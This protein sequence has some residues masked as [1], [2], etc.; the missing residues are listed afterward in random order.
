MSLTA[1]ESASLAAGQSLGRLKDIL[2]VAVSPEGRRLITGGKE[3][4]VIVWDSAN[5]QPLFPLPLTGHTDWVPSVAFS[6]DGRKMVSGCFDRTARVWDAV[7]GLEVSV[8]KGHTGRITS[9]AFAPD[10]RQIATASYDGTVKI[11]DAASGRE[12]DTLRGHTD[13]VWCVA[14]SPKGDRIASGGLDGTPRIRNARSGEGVNEV[15]LKGHAGMTASVDFSPDGR[16]V[17]TSGEDRTARVWDAATGRQELV[18][19]GHTSPVSS[20]RFFPD[21][22]RILT[23]GG[24]NRIKVWD[25]ATGRELLSLDPR[26]NSSGALA[27][28]PDGRKIVGSA[29]GNTLEVWEAATPGQVAAWEDD[30]RAISD[31]ITARTRERTAKEERERAIQASGAGAIRQWLVLAPVSIAA[32]SVNQP[33]L[34]QIPGENLLRPAAGDRVQV[35]G[36]ELIWQEV[37]LTDNVLDFNRSTGVPSEDCAG[38]AVS[39][40]YAPRAM[41]GLR[42]RVGMDDTGVVYLNGQR[43]HQW[44]SNAI[45]QI[46]RDTVPDLSL[47]EGLNVLVFK[48]LNGAGHWMGSIRFTDAQGNPVTDIQVSTKATESEAVR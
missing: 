36:R 6:P 23:R 19:E 31:R 1:A 10:S 12:L 27:L 45:F 30:A 18:L 37:T 2:A 14:L 35:A 25:A 39:Y 13:E 47:N 17:V 8:L 46:D 33:A 43:V 40:L 22:R 28:F 32:S 48:V 20:A 7:T 38:Y 5:G 21:Q 9:V 11:W 34:E 42:M 15:V 26:P 24:D 4:E 16:R 44:V 29:M 41:S 3:G